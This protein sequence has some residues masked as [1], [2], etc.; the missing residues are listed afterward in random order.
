[1]TARL[2][3]L[4]VLAGCAPQPAS[5]GPATI[6]RPAGVTGSVTVCDGPTAG[7]ICAP[8]GRTG[9]VVACR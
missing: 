9:G 7:M 5:H 1:M 8:A 4:L 2:L 6:C 3:L